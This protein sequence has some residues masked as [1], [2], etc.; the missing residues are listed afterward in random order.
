MTSQHILTSEF[1]FLAYLE[2]QRAI[3]VTCCSLPVVLQ[4]VITAQEMFVEEEILTPLAKNCE[5]VEC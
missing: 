2:Q 3:L 5:R 1:S 4:P